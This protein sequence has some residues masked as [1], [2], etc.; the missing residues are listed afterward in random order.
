M[1]PVA[2]ELGVK[3]RPRVM[4]DTAPE[5]ATSLLLTTSPVWAVDVLP[6]YWAETVLVLELAG[7]DGH[8]AIGARARGC[9]SW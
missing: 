8:D 9:R 5:V 2:A 1:E 6:A 4:P 3:L 7:V